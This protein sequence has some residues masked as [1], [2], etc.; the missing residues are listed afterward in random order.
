MIP[1]YSITLQEANDIIT[2]L[3][4]NIKQNT[5]LPTHSFIKNKQSINSAT[6]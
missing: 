4:T 3:L 2:Q 6:I 1:T 5:T